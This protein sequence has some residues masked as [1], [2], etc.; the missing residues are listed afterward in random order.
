[1][2]IAITNAGQV[3]SVGDFRALFPQ[4]SFPPSGP[5]DEF[6]AQNNALKVNA[7]R[8]HDAATQKLVACAPYIEGRSVYTVEVL[9]MTA[10]DIAARK[11]TQ[12]A[13]IR[14]QRN[15]LLRACDWTQLGDSPADTAKWRL[16][17][18]ELREV[19]QQA[20]FP[21]SVSWPVSP[22]VPA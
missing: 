22:D 2:N 7:W 6:L 20:G 11:A 8:P 19:P 4:T 16:Y 12:A 10:A 9:P 1:M 21:A 13:S 14:A 5:S 3:V 17:R 15:Q 18:K